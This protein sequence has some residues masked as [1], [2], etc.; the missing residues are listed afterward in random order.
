M[1][2]LIHQLAYSMGGWHRFGNRVAPKEPEHRSLCG[3]LGFPLKGKA[4]PE[5]PGKGELWGPKDVQ[6]ALGKPKA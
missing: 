5:R 2:L 4:H 3:A 6:F 1:G